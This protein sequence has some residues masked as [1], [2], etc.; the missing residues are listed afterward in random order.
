[1]WSG[2]LLKLKSKYFWTFRYQGNNWDDKWILLFKRKV[3]EK[4]NMS[5]VGSFPSWF[6]TVLVTSVK[7]PPG[8]F[9]WWG[10]I[11]H[12]LE[13]IQLFQKKNF[14]S[15]YCNGCRTTSYSKSVD[16]QRAPK[17]AGYCRKDMCKTFFLLFML[18]ALKSQK[19]PNH[20]N[21]WGH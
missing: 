10:A 12:L 21:T 11:L 3:Q 4:V 14:N 2:L 1:M 19:I 5:E 20:A 13:N 6:C 15:T 8:K 18:I 7:V 9:Y 17:S 16:A